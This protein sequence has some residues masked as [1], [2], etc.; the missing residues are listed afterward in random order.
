MFSGIIFAS[1]AKDAGH[2]SSVF[3]GTDCFAD[4]LTKYNVN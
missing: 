1:F 2:P 3:L 4:K